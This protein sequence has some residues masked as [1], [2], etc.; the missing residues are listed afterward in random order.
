[1]RLAVLG[2]EYANSKFGSEAAASV[3]GLIELARKIRVSG[4]HD[5]KAVKCGAVLSSGRPMP[6][7]QFRCASVAAKPEKPTSNKQDK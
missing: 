3:V 2:L 6:V 5:G 7:M 4:K 1:M